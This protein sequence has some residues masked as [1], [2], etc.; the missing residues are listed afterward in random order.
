MTL[1]VHRSDRPDQLAA[2]L[3]A[4]LRDDPADVFSAE[5]VIVPARGVER[6]L[7]QRLSHTLGASDAKDDGI[8]AGLRVL[9]PAS[10]VGLLLS[11]DRDDPWHSDRLVWATLD[12]ID[13]LCS[14]PGFEAIT[15][16]LGAGEEITGDPAAEWERKARQARRYVVARRIAG[17][18]AAYARDRPQML[19]EWERGDATDGYG[20]SLPPDLTWQPPLWRHVVELTLDRHRLDESVTAR[21]HRVVR[22]LTDGSIDPDLPQRV[23]FFGYTRFTRA[24]RELIQAL[25]TTRDVHLW[26]P[27]P[28]PSLW[29]DIAAVRPADA[30]PA[31]VDDASALTARNPLLATLARDVRELEQNLL[32]MQPT[33]TT[34]RPH[35][36]TVES[37]L[38]LLQSDIRHN[39]GPD[40][41]R[42]GAADDLSFQVHA[43]HGRP[44]Q[45]EVL[46]E[47]LTWM[48]AEGQGGLQP[49]DIV[50]MCP[51]IE[52]F[53]PLLQATFGLTAVTSDDGPDV[54]PHPGQ[55][56]RLQLADRALGATNPLFDL[57][58]R[59][60][61]I[62]AGRLTATEVLDLAAHESVRHRFGFDDDAL[63]RIG[64]WV[65]EVDVR[66]GFDG[67]HRAEY[68]LRGFEGYTWTPAMDRLA[69]GVAVGRGSAGAAIDHAPVDD[70][71]S[72][73]VEL[74]GRFLEL[75]ERVK[76]AADDVRGRGEVLKSTDGSFPTT[77]W[78]AWLKD[79]VHAL[80]DV[81]FDDRWQ[82]AQIDRELDAVAAAAGDVSLRLSDIRM[83]LEQRW[84][85]RPSRSNFRT[86]AITVCSMVP[87]RSVP[88]QAVVVLGLDDGLYPRSPVI[89][90]DDVL[91]RRP[92]VGERDP[93]SEDRQLL[94]DAVM[95]AEKYFV[96]IYAGFDE[97]SGARRPPAVPL[98][99]LIAVARR[100]DAAASS[101]ADEAELP[102]VRQHPLQAFDERNFTDDA[103][104]PGGTFDRPSLDGALA[105]RR[106]R[107]SPSAPPPFVPGL[108]A[109]HPSDTVTIDELTGFL[110]NPA[111]D[112]LRGRLGIFVPRDVDPIDDSVP[113][114]LDSLQTWQ[115]GD[116]ALQQVVRGATV[117]AAL[118]QEDRRGSFP[119]GSLGAKARAEVQS[120]LTALARG[121][122][123]PDD[124][125]VRS[126]DIRLDL[127]TTDE[128]GTPGGAVRFTGVVGGLYGDELRQHTFS[129]VGARQLI[130]AW[131]QLL[132]VAAT[133]PD[134]DHH[135]VLNGRKGTMRLRSP[136][137][138]A[139]QLLADLAQLRALGQRYPMGVPPKTAYSFTKGNRIR[140]LRG[141]PAEALLLQFAR[142]DWEGDRFDGENADPY[143]VKILGRGAPIDDIAVALRRFARRIWLPLLE[144]LDDA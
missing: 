47:V 83:L 74:V 90:G 136:G 44:R 52:A 2:G 120:D 77:Q 28:S 96:A 131:V 125:P 56:L 19:A 61:A 58:Q 53:A 14:T 143:W 25:A 98:Q 3:A 55:Q 18:F 23:S 119:P 48:L 17:L 66:W 11:R 141:D 112:F 43:C 1:H 22:G 113:I 72:R 89:D 33:I 138:A 132:A 101:G 79:T 126:V 102:F 27:H 108:L 8:C 54:H 76:R 31:R 16:H 144:H 36:A 100:T 4:M 38:S 117:D 45:V 115:I 41:A 5:V 34:P 20:Q 75:L 121:I 118:Q 133:E 107:E 116:R 35:E 130:S 92:H 50:V 69:L 42:E 134:H 94:L 71:G 60:I 12:A 26:L 68:G 78:M 142:N 57:A 81:P 80:A 128:A 84:G 91:A 59:L 124:P 70:I 140:L 24:D 97:R 37:R 67:T 15:R 9:T 62:V 82:L 139:P 110:H 87:M 109:P 6:W 49:R 10:L 106:F 127:Q 86:G 29:D 137:S 114:A 135:A 32:S 21:H 88:H 93:R 95:A 39:Q 13:D 105:L 73:E 64:T 85:G 46:R 40:P 122:H 65:E 99:E 111:R 7:G 104:I 123:R 103:P 30:V 51:D 63:S 129:R